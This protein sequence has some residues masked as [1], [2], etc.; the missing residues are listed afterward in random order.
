VIAAIK[1]RKLETK[2]EKNDG[3][4]CL[5]LFPVF[6]SGVSALLIAGGGDDRTMTVSLAPALEAVGGEFFACLLELELFKAVDAVIVLNG[7]EMILDII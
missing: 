3:E 4:E 1:P 6:L 5:L 7:T 2:L